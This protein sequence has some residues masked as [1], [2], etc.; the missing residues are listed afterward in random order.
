MVA[1]QFRRS[2]GT[3]Q[4]LQDRYIVI[5]NLR[6]RRLTA[7]QTARRTVGRH[8][9]CISDQTVRNRL[10]EAGLRTRRPLCRLGIGQ[11]Q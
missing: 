4:L 9:R 10:Q 6:D 3:L 8:G 7:M 5:S 1:Q 11:K 2:H